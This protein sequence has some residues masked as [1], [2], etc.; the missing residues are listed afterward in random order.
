MAN[1]QLLLHIQ[2]YIDVSCQCFRSRYKYEFG[3]QCVKYDNIQRYFQIE[4]VYDANN[5]VIKK[6]RISMKCQ[7]SIHSPVPPLFMTI[8]FQ[9]CSPVLLA[10]KRWMQENELYFP[11]DVSRYIAEFMPVSDKLTLYF[12]VS[13]PITFPIGGVLHTADG[14]QQI[15]HGHPSWQFLSLTTNLTIPRHLLVSY[16]RYKVRMHNKIYSLYDN[17]SP[18][19]ELRKDMLIFFSRIYH[20]DEIIAQQNMY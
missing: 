2:R 8:S 13:Y 20:F 11:L 10:A 19:Y 5:V 15:I 14:E 16:F 18:V 6:I 9:Y 1:Q 12:K 3:R 4:D 17:W 7:S